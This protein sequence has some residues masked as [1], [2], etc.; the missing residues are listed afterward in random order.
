[1]FCIMLQASIL[2]EDNLGRQ[3]IHQA[4]QAG[5]IDSIQFLVE[6]CSVNPATPS[7]GQ[8]VTPLHV[9]AKV[10]CCC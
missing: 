4:A 5:A 10:R 9:A 6:E 8:K 3:A 1:M 7:S 2:R